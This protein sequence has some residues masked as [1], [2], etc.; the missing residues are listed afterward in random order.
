MRVR[1]HIALSTAGAVLLHPWLR[2][3]AI[4]FWAGSVLIDIDHY[5]WFCLRQRCCNPLAAM[6]FFN[7]AHPPQHA[8]TRVLHTPVAP[9][10]VALVSTHRRSLLPV[11]L[12]MAVH[13]TLDLRHE[14]RMDEAR[15]VAMERDNCSCQVCGTRTSHVG[16]HLRRQ[17]WLLPS[18]DAQ[19]LVALC[20]PCHA[21]A[22]SRGRG[23][24]AWR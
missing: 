20:A 21:A 14:L 17:P 4:G 13:L 18:Y 9:L 22:H 24:A 11:A 16:T 23:A 6:R 2:R 10:A 8:A 15:A 5:L 1:D 12:G 7:E 19:N 3:R